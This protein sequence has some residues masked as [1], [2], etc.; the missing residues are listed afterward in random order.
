M[1]A[2]CSMLFDAH[3]ASNY[4]SI[5]SSSLPIMQEQMNATMASSCIILTTLHSGLITKTTTAATPE[6]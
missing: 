3:Y 5:I 2:L 6:H 1:P 4:A